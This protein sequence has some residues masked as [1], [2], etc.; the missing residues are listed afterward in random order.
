MWVS[1]EN[2]FEVV[3][4]S[5]RRSTL[6]LGVGRSHKDAAAVRTSHPIPG[7]CGLYY[8]EIKIISKGRDG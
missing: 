6:I 7:S 5:W 2:E 4:V 3:H 1:I 8:F